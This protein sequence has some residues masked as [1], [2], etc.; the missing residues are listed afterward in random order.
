MLVIILSRETR[1]SM[2]RKNVSR[3]VVCRNAVVQTETHIRTL[4]DDPK[5]RCD[6]GMLPVLCPFVLRDT[7]I[8]RRAGESQDIVCCVA[9][10]T[11]HRKSRCFNASLRHFA[12]V[13]RDT[14]AR[15]DWIRANRTFTKTKGTNDGS[16]C[17]SHRGVFDWC[18]QATI[19][20]PSAIGAR[21]SFLMLNA[22]TKAES[23][24]HWLVE[25]ER[26]KHQPQATAAT[27]SLWSSKALD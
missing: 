26:A 12:L 10:S 25:P 14:L 2:Q 22:G 11:V 18:P 17:C 8:R 16:K 5:C 4:E 24:I 27:C 23:K 6:E 9:A 1:N 13:R 3:R 19:S 15:D 21:M 20:L 7:I